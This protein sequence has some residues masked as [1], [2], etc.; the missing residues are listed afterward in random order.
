MKGWMRSGELEVGYQ[1]QIFNAKKP[2][3]ATA[4][5]RLPRSIRISAGVEPAALVVTIFLI[6]KLFLPSKST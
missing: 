1:T 4:T 3:L 6:V 2:N 5:V